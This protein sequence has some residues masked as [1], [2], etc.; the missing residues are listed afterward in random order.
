MYIPGYMGKKKISHESIIINAG[1]C[2]NQS[3]YNRSVLPN[4]HTMSKITK[5]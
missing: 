4:I 2:V 3:V 5:L 1:M